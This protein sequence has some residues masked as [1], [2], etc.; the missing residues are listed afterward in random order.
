[1]FKL[2]KIKRKT[3]IKCPH[4]KK[5]VIGYKH[6]TD[7]VGFSCLVKYNENTSGTP[8]TWNNSIY[9]YCLKCED[10]IKGIKKLR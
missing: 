4:C 7:E 8:I 1:V 10:E 5:V 2:K 3:P 6:P 9:N